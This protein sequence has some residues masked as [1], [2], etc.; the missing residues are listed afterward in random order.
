MPVAGAEL[1]CYFLIISII[2][3][4]MVGPQVHLPRNPAVAGVFYPGDAGAC[5]AQAAACLKSPIPPLPPSG[6]WIGGIAPHAGWI[7]SGAIAG[8][9]IASLAA[10]APDRPKLDLIVVFGAVHTP[11]PLDCA[12]LDSH[13]AWSLP[14]GNS[15]LDC[16]ITNLLRQS[17]LFVSA[18][19]FHAREHAIEVEMPLL[20]L[21][22][23]G[24]AI[25][26]VE[27][28]AIEAAAAIGTETARQIA[29]AGLE[30]VYLAS[31]DFTHYGP[32]YHFTP[33]GVGIRAMSWAKDNDC[34]LLDLITRLEVDQI[35][36]E[37]RGHLNACG[38]G[39]ITALLAA[40]RHHGATAARVLTHAT[41]YETL[42]QVA[43]QA[44]N[45]S[46]GYASIL[47]A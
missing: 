13:D 32:N 41:S 4:D 44:P 36:P 16:R 24:I 8:Q 33:A 29:A 19:Q 3:E 30:A 46:V 39:A 10:R 26:P 45:N 28:P 37:V 5:R 2:V 15:T 23:P 21:A 31:T 18:E 25:L 43:P 6:A 27:V 12:A 42:A 7:C 1:T 40:C 34:R 22:F 17:S 20:Q 35:I 11:L 38:A 9:T 47:V 14:S